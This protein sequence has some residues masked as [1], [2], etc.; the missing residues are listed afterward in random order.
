MI[1]A[2]QLFSFFHFGMAFTEQLYP[3]L[4]HL[5]MALFLIFYFKRNALTSI[6]AILS[7]YLFCQIGKWVGLLAQN[8]SGL[9]WVMYT[10]RILSM[11]VLGAWLLRYAAEPVATILSRPRKTVLIFGILPFVYYL[12]DYAVTVYTNLLYN[13]SQLIFEFLPFTLCIAYLI[14][15]IVY[16]KEYEEKC[17]AER[18]TQLMEIQA[19]QSMKEI[20]TIRRTEYDIARIRHDMRHFLTNIKTM[21]QSGSSEKATGYIDQ[22]MDTVGQ[23]ALQKFCDN[24]LVNMVLSYYKNRMD[25]R[26]IV[27]QA[28]VA[29]AEELPCSDMDFT[30]ILANG[31]ENA[32][33]AVSVLPEEMRTIL[34]DLHMNEKKLLLSIKNPCAKPPLILDGIPVTNVPGHGFGTQS[35]QYVTEKLNGNCQFAV[36]DGQFVLRVIL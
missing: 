30:S 22:M 8:L 1:Y 29:I 31:L 7:A 36:R 28:S 34:L 21:I 16:F 26:K 35:I 10:C 12:F 2:L 24:N 25:D 15:C 3:L 14:F 5:P 33:Q 9:D 27:F 17:E 32:L 20:E 18:R 19:V 6:F 13:G 23:T 11:L 4:S